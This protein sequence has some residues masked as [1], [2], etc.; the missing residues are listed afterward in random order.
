MVHTAAGADV[1]DAADKIPRRYYDET[2]YPLESSALFGGPTWGYN[3][4]MARPPGKLL[5]FGVVAY[6]KR[7][8]PV[9]GS[10]GSKWMNME[11]GT[12]GGVSYT[13]HAALLHSPGNHTTQQTTIS[14]TA[15]APAT[16]Q[17][18]TLPSEPY[19]TKSK[20][21]MATPLLAGA[22]GPRADYARRRVHGR[23]RP[24]SRAVLPGRDQHCS[25]LRVGSTGE[26]SRGQC[27]YLAAS[28]GYST[29]W[30]WTPHGNR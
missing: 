19:H 5:R 2:R 1:A 17:T 14:T 21:I 23:A 7:Q 13:I 15:A 24:S 29:P 25:A 9:A 16:P 10:K 22:G 27:V 4:S 12:V 28:R 30:P 8:A 18:T 6:F 20:N 26:G 11:P 3:D